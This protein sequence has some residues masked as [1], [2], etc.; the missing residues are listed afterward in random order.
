MNEL[1]DSRPSTAQNTMVMPATQMAAKIAAP[2]STAS[3]HGDATRR[4]ADVDGHD[5]VPE[6]DRRLKKPSELTQAEVAS[7]DLEQRATWPDQ[8]EVEVPVADQSRQQVEVTDCQ[9]V[10]ENATP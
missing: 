8:H 5:G 6:H 9:L 10:R 7:D 4:P 2:A 1:T 3:D